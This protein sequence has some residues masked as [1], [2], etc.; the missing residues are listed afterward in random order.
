MF[1]NF[2]T[3]SRHSKFEAFSNL[4]FCMTDKFYRKLWIFS[5][6][7]LMLGAC[8]ESRFYWTVKVL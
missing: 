2:L 1:L 6:F 4:L 5:Y 8:F 3:E 7:A